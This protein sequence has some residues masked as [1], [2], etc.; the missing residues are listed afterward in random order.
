ML[1]L[2]AV[3]VAWVGFIAAGAHVGYLALLGNAAG[4]RAGGGPIADYVKSRWPVALITAGVGLIGALFLGGLLAI[5][6]GAGV[7][8]FG[9]QALQTTRKRFRSGG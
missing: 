5:A 8:I 3:P 4:K 2:I 9:F 7:G 1:D 6:V